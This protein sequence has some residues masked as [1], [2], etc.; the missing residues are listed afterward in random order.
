[1]ADHSSR[2]TRSDGRS[3]Q[4]TS[5]HLLPPPRW[6]PAAAASA[7][8]ATPGASANPTFLQCTQPPPKHTQAHQPA[9]AATGCGAWPSSVRRRA[10]TAWAPRPRRRSPPAA[11]S[12]VSGRL[13][14]C[15]AAAG[16]WQAGWLPAAGQPPWGRQRSSGGGNGGDRGALRRGRLPHPSAK[17]SLA[18]SAEMTTT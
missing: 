4:G 11:R 13:Q 10:P 1:M 16:A 17:A 15:P 14:S 2:A 9:A 12:A 5:A 18:Y 7:P 6:A 3:A 8:A